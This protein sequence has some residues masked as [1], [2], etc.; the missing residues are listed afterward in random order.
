MRTP[1]LR[2]QK[3]EHVRVHTPQN[4]RSL[5][6]R[7]IIFCRRLRYTAVI[8]GEQFD[9][10]EYSFSHM[11]A[12]KPRHA[13][14]YFGVLDFQVEVY[15]MHAQDFYCS[16]SERTHNNRNSAHAYTST[17]TVESLKLQTVSMCMSRNKDKQPLG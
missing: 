14:C 15:G 3:Q 8:E 1:R 6:K 12:K 10:T 9:A 7:R 16:R 13:L 11:L 5:E 17:S 4:V 2:S